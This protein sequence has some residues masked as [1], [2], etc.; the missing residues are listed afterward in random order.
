MPGVVPFSSWA[1]G[2]RQEG[3]GAEAARFR[4]PEQGK[5]INQMRMTVAMVSPGL[6]GQNH[7]ASGADTFGQEM[8]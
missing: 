6:I 7:I 1:T 5:D 2:V 3:R 4:Y 8:V